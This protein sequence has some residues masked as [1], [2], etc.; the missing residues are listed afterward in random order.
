M[1]C[2]PITARTHAGALRAI[3]NSAAADV[4]ELRM[5]L[6]Q[7]GRLVALID[8]ARVCNEAVRVLVTHRRAA[9]SNP[10]QER[11]RIDCL[12]DAVGLGTDYVDVEVQTGRALREELIEAI[13]CLQHRTALIV[14]HHDF[15]RT[16]SLKTLKALFHACVKAGA[17]IV[18]IVTWAESPRDN[19]RVL[20]LMNDAERED[21]DLINF[22][23]GPQGRI[24]R[25]AAP[26]MGSFLSYVSL[27]KGFQ[28]AP[29]QLTI[30]EMNTVMKIL[31]RDP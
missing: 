24:S 1:I 8:Q 6:I 27:R 16:P 10:L 15:Q 22:C 20:S 28:S 5:D 19:L 7:N 31:R 25:I 4:I 23:M 12:K 14:S 2:I 9:K 21:V 11:R 13:G 26:L 17:D 29:G 18:K 30:T 3:E